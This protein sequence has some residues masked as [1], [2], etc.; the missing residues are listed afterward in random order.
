[1]DFY[2]ICKSCNKY[3]YKN[4]DTSISMEA[5]IADSTKQMCNDAYSTN[6]DVK[7]WQQIVETNKIRDIL[8]KFNGFS[9][10]KKRLYFLAAFRKGVTPAVIKALILK[11]VLEQ[12]FKLKLKHGFSDKNWSWFKRLLTP[13]LEII[14]RN[15][16]RDLLGI[17]E[18]DLTNF[19]ADGSLDNLSDNVLACELKACKAEEKLLQD[20]VKSRQ[21]LLKLQSLIKTMRE[22]AASKYVAATVLVQKLIPGPSLGG[23]GS[24]KGSMPTQYAEAG[25]DLA[26]VDTECAEGIR[27]LRTRI[28]AVVAQHS[29]IEAKIEALKIVAA[30]A[31]VSAFSPDSAPALPPVPTPFTPTATATAPLVSTHFTDPDAFNHQ[32]ITSKKR[33][34]D[35]M[36]K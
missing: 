34:R 14:E 13:N 2:F 28:D 9:A 27:D 11:L 15:K 12:K 16:F 6:E 1:M 23:V 33:L 32:L 10:D 20:L 7:K 22:E 19:L 8:N 36:R 21:E 18:E 31:P 29:E 35:M 5:V 26:D 30:T 17:D 25:E 24:V 3:K 4:T